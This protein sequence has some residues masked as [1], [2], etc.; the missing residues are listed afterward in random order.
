MKARE[1]AA[2]DDLATWWAHRHDPDVLVL[3]YD[4]MQRDPA[5]AT[6]QIAAFMGVPDTPAGLYETVTAQC[7]HAAMAATRGP[8][9]KDP[10]S[11]HNLADVCAVL[12]GLRPEDRDVLTGKV[13]KDGGTSGQGK[14]ALPGWMAEDIRAAWAETIEARF[15]F[16]DLD[17]MIA[18]RDAELLRQ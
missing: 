5:A 7:S 14:A 8:G 12:L 16:S 13:R 3:F 6:A 11:E 2:L 9:G 1:T 4:S 15:G 18:A 10:F 17:E